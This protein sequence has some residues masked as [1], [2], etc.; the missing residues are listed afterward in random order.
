MLGSLINQV[1]GRRRRLEDVLFETEPV[2]VHDI[3]FRIRKVN[4]ID[5]ARGAKVHRQFFETYA[6][7][8]VEQQG[9]MLDDKTVEKIKDHFRDTFMTC[10]VEP[11]L[12]Y[13]KDKDK[14]ENEKA[15]VVDNLFT[16]WDLANDLY[17]SIVLHSFGKKKRNWYS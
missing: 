10:V 6:K 13:A 17:A 2:V 1:F 9:D 11:K 8:G 4:P 5:F 7:A 16:D 3:R 14:P 15:T 12:C